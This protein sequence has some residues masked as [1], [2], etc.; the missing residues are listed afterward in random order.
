MTGTG[1]RPTMTTILAVNNW[2]GASVMNSTSVVA[3]VEIRN[4]L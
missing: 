1:G 3:R 2:E 4:G